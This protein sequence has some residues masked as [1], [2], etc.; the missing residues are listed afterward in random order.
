MG[1]LTTSLI[2]LRLVTALVNTILI[3]LYVARHLKG[4]GVGQKGLTPTI[5]LGHVAQKQ[6]KLGL[7]NL[8][9]YVIK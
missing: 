1:W 2:K 7:I 4:I 3:A 9:L 6:K 8:A 5:V